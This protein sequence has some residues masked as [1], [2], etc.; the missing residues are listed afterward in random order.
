M[1]VITYSYGERRM[2]MY[3]NELELALSLADVADSIALRHFRDP[4]LAVEFKP[5]GS[6]VSSADREIELALRAL[7]DD[8]RPG[9]AVL[10]EE[11]GASGEGDHRWYL[12]PIDG[13]SNFVAGDPEWY[14]LIALA[15]DSRAVVG[16]AS[17]PALGERWWAARGMGAF[18]DGSRIRVSDVDELSDATVA[19]DWHQSLAR[20]VSG[21]PLATLAGAAARV[22]PHSGHNHLAIASGEAELTSSTGFAWDFAPTKVLIEEAGGRFTDLHGRDAFDGGSAL[23]S[24]GRVHDQALAALART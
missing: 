4:G 14:V 16:I 23:V 19:D 7:L 21:Y 5:D 2:D 24:N 15:V 17:A 11:G 18:R 9:H 20:G 13:T 3:G 10:G 22:R 12:D 8:R 6:P 1:Y